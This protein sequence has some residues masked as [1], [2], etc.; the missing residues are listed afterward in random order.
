MDDIQ[1]VTVWIRQLLPYHK[2]TNEYRILMGGKITNAPL[3]GNSKK[4]EASG[5]N[6]RLTVCQ[7]KF[8]LTKKKTKMIFFKFLKVFLNFVKSLL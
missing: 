7:R 4:N 2:E 8:M 5:G 1:A 3:P 6:R